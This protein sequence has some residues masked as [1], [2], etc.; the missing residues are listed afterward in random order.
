MRPLDLIGWIAAFIYGCCMLGLAAYALHG[1]YLLRRFLRHRRAALAQEAAELASPLPPDAE[2]PV[3]LVQL[4]TFNERDVLHRVVDA[5]GA[6]DWPRNK[7]RIQVLDDSTDDSVDI[8]RAAVAKLQAFGLDAVVLHRQDRTGFK[9]GALE[10][11]MKASDAEYIAIFDADFVPKPDFL[12]R[13]IRPLLADPGLALV[14]GRWEHLNRDENLLTRVQAIGIDGHFAVEQGARAWSGL[15]MNF[16]GTCGLWRR[17][18]IEEAGGWEHDTLTEDLDL[19]YRAQLLGWRCTYRLGLDVPGEL[20]ATITAWRHQQFRWAK[21]SQQTVRKLASRVLGSRWPLH[22]KLASLLHL[23]HYAVHPL[24]LLSLLVAPFAVWLCPAVPEPLLYCGLVCFVLGVFSPIL[25]YAVSQWVLR[26]KGWWKM[27]QLIPAMAG[28]GTGI[29][30]SNSRA[31]IQAW[32]GVVS[33]FVRTPKAG[34]A[35]KGSY[36]A[37]GNTGIPELLCSAWAV[38][39]MVLG[40]S[41][42]RMVLAPLLL[43]YASGFAWVGGLHLI[44]WW[45]E[46]AEAR[47]EAL[48]NATARIGGRAVTPILLLLAGLGASACYYHLGQVEPRTWQTDPTLFAG[49]GFGAG[50]CY[51]LASWLVLRRPGGAWTLALILA[52]GVLF[53]L[54]ATGIAPSADLN[55]YVV[56]GRQWAYGQNPYAVPPGNAQAQELLRPVLDPAV[57]DAVKH[58]ERTAIH[59]PVSVW[60]ELLISHID[61]R[62]EMMKLAA[63]AFELLAMV[64][65]LAM[66]VRAGLPAA[67]LLLA[68]WNP[69][70]PI[71][72]SGEG[73][74]DSLMVLLFCMALWLLQRGRRHAGVI[75]LTLATLAK[76]LAGWALLPVLQRHGWRAAIL[77]LAVAILVFLPFIPAGSNLASGVAAF[78][79]EVHF[80]GA[81]E[82]IYRYLA[83][84]SGEVLTGI[85]YTESE[86][87]VVVAW[88]LL[89]TLLAGTW[90]ILRRRP[91]AAAAAD[92][93]ALT[94]RLVA[95]LLLCLPTCYPWYMLLL[96]VCLPFLGRSPGALLW[97]AMTPAFWLHGLLMQERGGQWVEW[98]VATIIAHG[99]ALLLLLWEVLGRPGL[100]VRDEEP[101]LAAEG[102]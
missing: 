96:V 3:V 44:G 49:L 37:R 26:G 33:P 50:A 24:M 100:P 22:S 85:P 54:A 39:G 91:E 31:V 89:A 16:N 9:A 12:R 77:P 97:T 53:R 38:L 86:V 95:L 35:G 87:R 48:A 75:S 62:V 40:V 34:A 60:A 73:H 56:E 72:F 36:R 29:A 27:L 47:A 59:P 5:A 92:E 58:P 1:L 51:L 21:G 76:P 15:A 11:G 80:H 52:F 93:L 67:W 23:S 20:P 45:R 102:A 69:V 14:Q 17:R 4:P 88:L 68:L 74:R 79:H 84:A 90:L 101:N 10:A 41:A 61:S 28:I 78:S 19:S 83:C 99:P 13:A 82:P 6:L 30:I 70:G 65:V 66:L 81:L 46:Q 64:F 55:H 8:A 7:L 32:A 71:W 98:P 2:L 63:G 43:I 25:T 57:L 94:G 18:A 42:D